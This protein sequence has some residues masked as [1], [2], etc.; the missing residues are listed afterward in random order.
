MGRLCQRHCRRKRRYKAP[1]YEADSFNMRSC[2]WNISFLTLTGHEALYFS[3]PAHFFK[4]HFVWQCK[5]R[6]VDLKQHCLRR[7]CTCERVSR[8]PAR[9]WYLLGL[10]NWRSSHRILHSIPAS[11]FS[12]FSFLRKRK[13]PGGEINEDSST[14]NRRTISRKVGLGRGCCGSVSGL[15]SWPQNYDFSLNLNSLHAVVS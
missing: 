8:L 13:T 3:S 9:L 12:S 5:Y 11:S 1:N 14:E 10:S 2:G 4:L 15:M 6:H 7:S